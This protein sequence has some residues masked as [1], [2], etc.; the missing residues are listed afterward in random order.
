MT[1]KKKVTTGGNS[2]PFIAREREREREREIEIEI[3]SV[4]E[5]VSPANYAQ[6]AAAARRAANFGIKVLVFSDP[7]L[8]ARWQALRAQPESQQRRRRRPERA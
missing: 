7:A 5:L 2:G 8:M 4:A 1:L 3:E 6:A